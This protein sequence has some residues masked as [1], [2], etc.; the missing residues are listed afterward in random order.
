MSVWTL[1]LNHKTAPVAFRER[2]AFSPERLHDSLHDLRRRFDTHEEVAILST[3][4]RTEIYCA[5]AQS[6]CAQTL[7]WLAEAGD[8][9]AD[10]LHAHTDQLHGMDSARHAF[11]VASGLDS[12]VV[13]E[14]QI[15]GQ[16]KDAV[17]VAADSGALGTTLNQMF[18]RSFAVAKEVRSATAI[19]AQSV[20]MASTSLK[21]AM[22]LFEDMRQTQVLFIGA[23]EMIDLCLSHF[24]SKRPRRMVV[25]N[26]T[27]ARAQDLADKYGTEVMG[28]SE[29]AEALAQFDIVVSC[30][31]SPHTLLSLGAVQQALKARK[32]K[33]MLM[34]DLAVPRDIDAGVARLRDAYLYTVDDLTQAIQQAQQQ[35]M[36][37]VAP[38]E[39]IVNQGVHSF[40]TW[41]AK[42]KQVPVIQQLNSQANHWRQGELQKAQRRIEGGEDIQQV[43]EHMSHALMK[44]MLNGPL[45]E[46]HHPEEDQRQQALAAVRQMFL[47]P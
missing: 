43:L 42:R 11:R 31:G 16:L 6:E 9:C 25:A 40:M 17:R 8:T 28:L 1:G 22:Q 4:N 24:A 2:F 32:R 27:W 23:G 47:S 21:L 14:S 7:S 29:V 46:L 3:C 41:L 36:S 37:A 15:L 45:R 12:M 5:G 38:A 18:Q 35:R 19:G 13:G 33:P 10:E 20:S 39:I 44:K 34:V 26:R 30:T